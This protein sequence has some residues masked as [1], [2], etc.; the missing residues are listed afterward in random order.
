MTELKGI[1]LN[2]KMLIQCT[3]SLNDACWTAGGI[4]PDLNMTLGDF[5][6]IFGW[7]GV[8]FSTSKLLKDKG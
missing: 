4:A 2:K 3:K 7:N 8:I 1:E 6:E 5:I